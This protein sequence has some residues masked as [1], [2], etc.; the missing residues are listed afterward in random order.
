MVLP[1]MLARSVDPARYRGVVRPDKPVRWA[2][3]ELERVERMRGLPPEEWPSP[4][5]LPEALDRLAG[6]LTELGWDDLACLARREE[7]DVYRRLPAGRPG[8]FGDRIVRALIALRDG[9]VEC[10][11]HGQALEVVEEL[12]RLAETVESA[13]AEAPAARYW[14]TLLLARTGRDREALESAAEEVAE[15]RERLQRAGAAPPSVELIHALSSYADRL[16]KVGRVAEAAEVGAE[17]MEGWARRGD[18]PLEFLRALD[19]RSERLVRGGRPE[20]ARACVVEAMGKVRRRDTHQAM[21]WRDLA[22][23]LLGLGAPEAAVSAGEEAVRLCRDRVRAR[24]GRHRELQEDEDWDD[25]PRL[26]EA[27]LR[28]RRD[29]ELRSSL[30][31]VREAERDLRDALFVLGDCLRRLGRGD[32]AAAAVAEA[33]ELPA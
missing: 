33:A 14:R 5:A 19:E 25:D 16:D 10:R 32:E 30:K 28:D 22:A 12:L 26:S 7:L 15:I 23:R 9:L 21:I 1:G 27:Y 3:D 20:A 11:R 8:E 31:E 6:L 29:K 18:A 17:V 13:R 4:T 24:R 2:R